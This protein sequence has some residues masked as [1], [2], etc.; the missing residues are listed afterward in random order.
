MAPK[1]LLGDMHQSPGGLGVA[2]L[3]RREKES[4]VAS[5]PRVLQHNQNYG[6]KGLDV[7]SF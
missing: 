2:P 3:E 4:Q 7:D 6:R 5:S 1:F